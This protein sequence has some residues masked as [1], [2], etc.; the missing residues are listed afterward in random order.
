M[1]LNQR[2]SQEGIRDLSMTEP[3]T[4]LGLACREDKIKLR[5]NKEDKRIEIIMINYKMIINKD[6]IRQIIIYLQ[7]KCNPEIYLK[8]MEA[9]EIK[10]E[11]SNNQD[12]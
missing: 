11:E 1:K 4:R 7:S 8:R 2:V 9:L 6:L 10:E 12:M 5:I 3:A